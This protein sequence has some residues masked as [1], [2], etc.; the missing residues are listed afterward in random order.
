MAEWHPGKFIEKITRKK[1]FSQEEAAITP[2]EDW[3]WL[4]DKVFTSIPDESKAYVTYIEMAEK[5]DKMLQFDF[6]SF[7]REI[8]AEE[9]KHHHKLE[10][11]LEEIAV[12]RP[13]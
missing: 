6:A 13:I 12:R 2:D 10:K 7:L 11:I 8:A 3:N 4:R 9:E 5:A 1:L